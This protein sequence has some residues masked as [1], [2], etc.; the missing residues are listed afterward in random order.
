VLIP[1]SNVGNLMLR[2][3][4]VAEIEAGRFHVYPVRTI[5]EGLELL[6]GRPAGERD[7]SGRFPPGT[8]NFAVERRLSDFAERA[9]LAAA[10][11]RRG[12]PQRGSRRR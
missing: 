9:R 1:A 12:K 7:L 5:D 2:G 6:T 3:D 4:V 11:A 8:I 10:P